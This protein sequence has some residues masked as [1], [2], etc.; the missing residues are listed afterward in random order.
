[1]ALAA[2][3]VTWGATSRSVAVDTHVP[4]LLIVHENVNEGWQ[5]TVNGRVLRATTVDGWQQAWL[6]PGGTSGVIHLRFTPQRAFSAGLIAGGGAAAL[7]ALLTAPPIPFR[8]RRR[9]RAR[10]RRPRPALS[11]AAPGALIRRVA[12]IGVLTL[13]GSV[14]GLAVG[15][16]LVVVDVAA[17]HRV[18]RP[19]GTWLAV[20]LT[21]GGASIAE[22]IGTVTSANSLASSAGVQFLCLVATGLVVLV[23]FRPSSR[24]PRAGEPAE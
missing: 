16:V 4:A 24:P 9:R 18:L 19:R 2:H 3:K 1:V 17:A 15:C 21:V 10:V 12:V 6:V 20:G 8:W 5:A 14:T 13:L 22:T 7:L 11:A 23:C